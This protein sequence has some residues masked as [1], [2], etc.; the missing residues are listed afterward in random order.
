MRKKE[1]SLEG[2]NVQYTELNKTVK[3]KRGQRSRKNRTD[4]VQTILQSGRGPKQIYKRGPKKK[5][6][7]MK[8]GENKVQT[9]RNENQ[10]RER[11][12]LIKGYHLQTINFMTENCIEFNRL[13][14]SDISIMKKHLTQQNVK[15]HLRY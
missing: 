12:S 7:E 9:D 15:Q 3:K 2:E 13:F 4:H 10:P 11:A 1:N 6:C 14:P 5:K 8:N